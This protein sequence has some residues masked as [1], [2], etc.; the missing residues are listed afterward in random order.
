MHTHRALT[1][2][3]SQEIKLMRLDRAAARR[4]EMTKNV[5]DRELKSLK[6]DIKRLQV[7]KNNNLW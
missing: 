2:S 5:L 4:M 3:P 1:P 7:E 6:Q